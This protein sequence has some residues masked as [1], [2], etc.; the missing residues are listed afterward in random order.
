MRAVERDVGQ[1]GERRESTTR[2]LPFDH[3]RHAPAA[4]TGVADDR[5]EEDCGINSGTREGSR[6]LGRYPRAARHSGLL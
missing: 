2:T 5:V 1:E 6:S 4:Y 3:S